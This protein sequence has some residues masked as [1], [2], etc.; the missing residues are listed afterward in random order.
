MNLKE[1]F[2]NNAGV[3]ILATANKEGIVNTAIYAR[4]HV[5]D[6]VTVAFVM[7][8]KLSRQNIHEN[9]SASYLFKENSGYKGVR[10][11]LK[12][13]DESEDQKLIAELSR[14]SPYSEEDGEK[15][16][17]V[18]FSVEYARTLIGDQQL[19]LS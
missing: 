19:E 15:R 9:H 4:P 13:V 3:G 14:R 8:N 6:D 1:Y 18:R 16:F 2:K 12:M 7:R 10:L 11:S 17:L 5:F